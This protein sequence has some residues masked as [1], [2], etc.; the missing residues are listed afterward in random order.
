MAISDRMFYASLLFTSSIY[1]HRPSKGKE[2]LGEK[3]KE[4]TR[5]M[6]EDSVI[7]NTIINLNSL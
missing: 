4:G 7:T 5:K 1:N 2:V 6:L 3:Y